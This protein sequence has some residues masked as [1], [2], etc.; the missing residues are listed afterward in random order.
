MN[1]TDNTL[2]QLKLGENDLTPK[3]KRL[4][5][6]IESIEDKV[7]MAK[8][9]LD[10]EKTEEAEEDYNSLL[11]FLQ[12][13]EEEL[14]DELQSIVKERE[15]QSKEAEE[16]AKKEK[17]DA[18]K[19][20]QEEAEKNVPQPKKKSGFGMFILGAVVLIATAGVVNVM[21]KK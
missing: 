3:A 5:S 14:N 15:K 16:K 12:D 1:K 11:E 2:A 6:K 10:E 7:R 13:S 19:L 4:I 8:E 9:L 18:E 20:A 21:N 17:S